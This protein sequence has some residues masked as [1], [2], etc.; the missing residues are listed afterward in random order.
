M[1][2]E[3][4]WGEPAAHITFTGTAVSPFWF[5]ND[6]QQQTAQGGVG[7][8]TLSAAD[9]GELAVATHYRTYLLTNYCRLQIIFH[10][11][12]PALCNNC[13]KYPGFKRLKSLPKTMRP[14]P[15]GIHIAW[16]LRSI[17]LP[18]SRI[19][20]PLVFWVN[21][22]PWP[23]WRDNRGPNIPRIWRRRAVKHLI[24]VVLLPVLK[25]CCMGRSCCIL[26]GLFLPNRILLLLLL[27]QNNLTQFLALFKKQKSLCLTLQLNYFVVLHSTS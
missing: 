14:H 13:C 24:Q 15:H 10:Q 20:P 7:A 9:T 8:N 6:F 23:T 3:H 16:K 5:P 19:W 18:I 12:L 21:A 4:G 27:L 17:E 26:Q 11:K 22:E 2:P 1:L 25:R